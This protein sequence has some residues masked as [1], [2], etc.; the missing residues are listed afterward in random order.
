[1]DLLNYI[2]V[3][4]E[5]MREYQPVLDST[6][7]FG[8]SAYTI[9]SSLVKVLQQGKHLSTIAVGKEKAVRKSKTGKKSASRTRSKVSRQI[10]SKKDVAIVVEIAR[11]AV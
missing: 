7:K 2:A 8:T 11:P 4:S 10:A 6:I 5:F 1:M 9:G 3:F